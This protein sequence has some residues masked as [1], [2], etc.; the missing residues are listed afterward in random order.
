MRTFSRADFEASREAWSDYGP[1][2]LF[3]RQLAADRGMIFPPSGSP[4]D[5]W[6]DP[7][8]SQR[9]IIYRAIEDTPKALTEIIRSSHSWSQVVRKLMTDLE[10]RRDDAD[11]RERDA[12]WAKLDDP[13]PQEATRRVSDILTRIRESAA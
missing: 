1:E 3:Y 13:S 4:L 6:E 9:A 8:P 10:R 11:L 7:Q 2:W 5:S 12:E